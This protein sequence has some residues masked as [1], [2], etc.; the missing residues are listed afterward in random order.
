MTQVHRQTADAKAMP[1]L[2]EAQ[3]RGPRTRA[4]PVP[5]AEHLLLAAL[6]ALQEGADVV[7][8]ADA[9]QHAQHRLVRAAVQRA[10]QCADGA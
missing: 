2:E 8:A 9:L 7:D 3:Q 1:A 10:V 4:A 5:E 6:D